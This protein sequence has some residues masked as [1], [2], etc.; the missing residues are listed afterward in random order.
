MDPSE[1][2]AARFLASALALANTAEFLD[3]VERIFR[4]LDQNL[5]TT[6]EALWQIRRLRETLTTFNTRL[7]EL[8]SGG[9]SPPSGTGDTY[10]PW[11]SS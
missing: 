9:E 8:S 11:S 3:A 10:L 6:T 1:R 7:R 4:E 2:A 5:L